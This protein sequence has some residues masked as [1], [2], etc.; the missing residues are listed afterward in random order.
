MPLTGGAYQMLMTHGIDA[1]A[2]D[3]S[4]VYFASAQRGRPIPSHSMPEGMQVASDN[5]PECPP[6]P[7]A[8]PLPRSWR[9]TAQAGRA[10]L[11]GALVVARQSPTREIR[12]PAVANR[13]MSMLISEI[14]A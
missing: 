12:L 11:A 3:A 14:S 6:S 9:Q 2:I 8:A 5:P 10:T 7:D 13:D 4:G 1:F